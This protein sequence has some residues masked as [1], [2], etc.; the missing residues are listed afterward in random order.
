MAVLTQ[1]RTRTYKLAA[2][3][4]VLNV[5]SKYGFSELLDFNAVVQ[6]QNDR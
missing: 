5:S 4:H 2:W 1:G 3:P 6:S